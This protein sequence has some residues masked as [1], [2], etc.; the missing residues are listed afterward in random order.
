MHIFYQC[1]ISDQIYLQLPACAPSHPFADHQELR[2]PRFSLCVLRR[3]LCT[4]FC[5]AMMFEVSSEINGDI[6]EPRMGRIEL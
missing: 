5:F 4:A 1:H 3:A 6:G 2:F